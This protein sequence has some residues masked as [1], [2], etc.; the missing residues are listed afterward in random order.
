MLFHSE[1][2]QESRD[3]FAN[4]CDQSATF[5]DSM[6]SDHIQPFVDSMMSD[7]IFDITIALLLSVPGALAGGRRSTRYLL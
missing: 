6:M 3:G 2:P 1:I 4:L 5:V 7:H